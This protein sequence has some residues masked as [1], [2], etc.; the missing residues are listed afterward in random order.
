MNKPISE[1]NIFAI[2]VVF[3]IFLVVNF[4]PNMATVFSLM[5]IADILIFTII[6]KKIRVDYPFERTTKNRFTSLIESLIIFAGFIF[7][8][9]IVLRILTPSIQS[10]SQSLQSLLSLYSTT[11]PALAGSF[12]FTFLAYGVIIPFVETRFFF[13]RVY[14]LLADKFN[15]NGNLKTTMTWVLA[16][17]VGAIFAIYHLTAR[18][19]GAGGTCENA[20]LFVTF[21]FGMISTLM[22]AHYRETKQA[23]WVHVFANSMSIIYAYGGLSVIGL[24]P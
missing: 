16:V 15:K 20:L 3:L 1:E 10:T 18:R 12:I 2:L 13:G 19:C 22:V 6:I 21:L 5:I 23:V 14:E 17:F 4:D 11:T 24:I 8:Q 7:I 9:T